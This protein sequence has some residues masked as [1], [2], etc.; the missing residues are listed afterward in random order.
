MGGL[1]SCLRKKEF[2]LVN[3]RFIVPLLRLVVNLLPQKPSGNPVS[4]LRSDISEGLSGMSSEEY[5]G[6]LTLDDGDLR[7]LGLRMLGEFSGWSFCVFL[8]QLL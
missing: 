4:L 5:S 7:N 8:R 1:C 3:A 2:V 6:V